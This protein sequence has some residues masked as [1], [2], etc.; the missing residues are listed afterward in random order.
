MK[1]SN[2]NDKGKGIAHGVGE[3]TDE[4]GWMVNLND[5]TGMPPLKLVICSM[6]PSH[7]LSKWYQNPAAILVVV[8]TPSVAY[9]AM[10]SSKQILLL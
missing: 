2:P 5:E 1:A 7:I 6:V 8:Y 3:D 9:A 10:F 4:L